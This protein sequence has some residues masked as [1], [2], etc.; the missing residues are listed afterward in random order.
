LEIDIIQIFVEDGFS[1]HGIICI[2]PFCRFQQGFAQ[3]RSL[4]K[5]GLPTKFCTERTIL[6]LEDKAFPTSECK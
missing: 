3:K 4:A 6:Y 5:D 2:H 1:L